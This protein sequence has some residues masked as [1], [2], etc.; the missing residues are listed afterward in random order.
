M[1]S[2]GKDASTWALASNEPPSLIPPPLPSVLCTA[3][4]LGFLKPKPG[5]ISET[6][7]ALHH[8]LE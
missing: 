2:L 6:S 5:Y 1:A 4:V 7:V 8:T 3:E